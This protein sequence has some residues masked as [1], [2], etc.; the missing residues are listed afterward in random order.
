VPV[1]VEGIEPSVLDPGKT[2]ADKKAFDEAAKKL[3]EL[4]R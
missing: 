4:F 3:V 1:T 2:W